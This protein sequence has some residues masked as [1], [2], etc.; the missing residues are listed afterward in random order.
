VKSLKPNS[1]AADGILTRDNRKEDKQQK[2]SRFKSIE[3]LILITSK[4][5]I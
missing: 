3:H 5:A 2:T 1:D 4:T